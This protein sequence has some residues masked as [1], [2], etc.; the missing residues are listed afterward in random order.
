MHAKPLPSF[1]R[2]LLT[3]SLLL[4]VVPCLARPP[5][6]VT[7]A[8]SA[9]VSLFD[10]M[11]AAQRADIS[12]GSGRLDVASAVEA[13]YAAALRNR[14][15]VLEAPDGNYRLERA[16]HIK[17]G[18]ELRGRGANTHFHVLGDSSGFVYHEGS[19][20]PMARR[21]GFSNLQ[22]SK[23]TITPTTG[24]YG[25]ELVGTR[26]NVWSPRI[27]NVS[28][29]GF[30]DGIRIVRPLFASIEGGEAYDNTRDGYAI[31]GDGTTV[32]LTQTFSRNNGRHGYSMIG[33]VSYSS[34]LTTGSDRNGGDGYYFGSDAR[35]HF[36]N[37][38]SLTAAGAEANRG[39]G[40]TI[41]DGENFVITT[42]RLWANAGH[43]LDIGG[44]RDIEIH[45][46]KINDNKGWGV[47]SGRSTV[48]SR[49]PAAITLTGTSL[50]ANAAGRIA[51]TA[52]VADI[53]P[54]ARIAPASATPAVAGSSAGTY[55]WIK[56]TLQYSDF[57]QDSGTIDY[58]LPKPLPDGSVVVDVYWKLN[59]EFGGAPIVA[60]TLELG[61]AQLSSGFFP[62]VNAGTGAGT[63]Y[64]Q[65]QVSERGTQLFDPLNKALRYPVLGG[66]QPVQARLRLTGGNG[67]KL[68]S[69]SMTVWVG[70]LRLP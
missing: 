70:Y 36:P 16:V 26:N 60:A 24:I 25:I 13:A 3:A 12:S 62:P 22:I 38:I 44:G 40:L 1:Y 57:A 33:N 2:F 58:Q 21:I 61:T 52:L 69:G 39:N 37:A 47:H 53:T 46:G 45:G 8:V 42:L 30:Q 51:D 54:A 50:A 55:Y 11:S 48:T 20:G 5:Q 18:I 59:Q 67:S 41:E 15:S 65:T 19:D 6:A 56:H 43:G 7:Q 64:K 35:N 27:I 14:W 66:P 29:R 10:F 34:F 31:V 23:K 49:L 68:R 17:P 63:G 32:S 28:V 9:P 4:C